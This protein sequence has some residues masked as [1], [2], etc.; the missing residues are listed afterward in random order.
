MEN[1]IN[2]IIEELKATNDLY[3]DVVEDIVEDA[4]GYG[5]NLKEQLE[6]HLKEITEHGCQ[7]TPCG[8]RHI[9]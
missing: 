3:K 1:K 9:E 8:S 4:E 7:S 2:E 5:G 6:T